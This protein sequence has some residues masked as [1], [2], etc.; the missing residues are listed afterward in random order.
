[1]NKLQVGFPKQTIRDIDMVEERRRYPREPIYVGTEVR[2][3]DSVLTR[4]ISHDISVGGMHLLSPEELPK[5]KVMELEINAP[6]PIITRGKVV[7]T[8]ETE[9]E[10]GKFF[11]TGIQFTEINPEDK[12]RIE[13]FVRD[14]VWPIFP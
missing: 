8:K 1:M 12:L 3:N 2:H 4:V 7:W 5:D 9:T 10:E 14:G 13:A 6:S 11:Q